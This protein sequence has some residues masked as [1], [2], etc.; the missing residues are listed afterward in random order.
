MF[1]G[2]K[3]E[4]VNLNYSLLISLRGYV[5]SLALVDT[6]GKKNRICFLIKES[7]FKDDYITAID[8]GVKKIVSQGLVKL[9]QNS[10]PAKIKSVEVVLNASFY[11]VYIKDLVIEKESK[12]ILTEDQFNKAVDKHSEVINANKEGKIIL[13]KDV[14]N[15]M[16]NGYSLQNPFNKE[17]E[18]LAVSFYASFVDKKIVDNIEEII[19]KSLNISKINF[20]TY[21]L[22]K[23]NALRNTFLNVGNYI[24]IDVGEKYTDVF[25]VENNALKYRKFFDFGSQQFTDEIAHKCSLNSSIV[26]SEL[27]MSIMGD[28]KRSCQPDIATSLAEQKKKWVNMLI[29]E[30]IDKD[31][32]TIPPRVFITSD[33]KI[34]ILFSQIITDPDFKKNIFGNEKDVMVVSCDNK[35]FSK[36][37]EY[38]EDVES[39]IF[40]TI[41]SINL[42]C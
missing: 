37:V 14:T 5:V 20:K 13:E 24:S 35:H 28:V 29:S 19:K 10:K 17:V 8:S 15:V 25:V 21:T 34:S 16:I 23:F 22:G 7:I 36:D 26:S 39:D 42:N 3:K 9:S 4:K 6:S 31:S 12:F 27:N 32:I 1:E 41:N 38:K 40:I 18:N 2:F 33:P 11:D 30:I